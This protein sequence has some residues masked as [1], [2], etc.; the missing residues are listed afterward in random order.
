MGPHGIRTSSNGNYL[1]ADVTTTNEIVVI[2]TNSLEIFQEFQLEMFH[3][4]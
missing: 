1:Y 4:G 2:D 3:S